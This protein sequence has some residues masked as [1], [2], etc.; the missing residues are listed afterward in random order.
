MAKH[1]DLGKLGE[2][3]AA[4]Y[5]I[6]KGFSILHT[7]WRYRKY[8]IDIIARYNETIVF[9]EVKTRT[10]NTVST[11]KDSMTRAKQK[12]LIEAADIYIKDNQTDIDSRIDLIT[13]FVKDRKYSLEHIEQ[14]VIPR[15]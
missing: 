5:L 15:W 7:N 3:I 4:R 12:Q 14:A 2:Q 6:N 10:P 8:E 9:V 13:I 11:P 1:N